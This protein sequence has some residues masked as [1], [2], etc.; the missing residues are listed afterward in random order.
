MAGVLPVFTATGAEKPYEFV[1]GNEVWQAG[2]AARNGTDWLALQCERAGCRFEPARVSVKPATWKRH[3]EDKPTRGQ[4]LTFSLVKPAPGRTIA[5]FRVSPKHPPLT[6]G[7]VTTYASSAAPFDRPASEGTL[8]IAVNLPDGTQALFVPMLDRDA[9]TFRLQLRAR[10][11]RQLLGELGRCSREVSRDYLLWAG[12]LDGDG[13]PD[14]LVSFKDADGEAVL[15]LSGAGGT[16]GE[17][18]VGVGGTY[19]YPPADVEC[20]GEGWLPR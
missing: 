7:P 17:P 18:L 9:A 12:E 3:Y 10:G 20:D 4:R 1:V 5:W 14:F 6:A 11:D 13:K 19:A 8:E 2:R 16:R 15:F